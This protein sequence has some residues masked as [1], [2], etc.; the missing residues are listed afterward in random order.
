MIFLSTSSSRGNYPVANT[1][2]VSGKNKSLLSIFVAVC[3]F[4]ASTI[5]RSRFWKLQRFLLVETTRFTSRRRRRR[6]CD[7]KM[8]RGPS[9]STIYSLLSLRFTR[10]QS[11][12]LGVDP[13]SVR[14]LSSSAKSPGL[15]HIAI[16]IICVHFIM[17]SMKLGCSVC[18][19]RFIL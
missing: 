17:L 12:K 1:W 13:L 10:Q 9:T 6:N 15:Y 16:R 2:L 14:F 4:G 7:S 3:S 8:K 11:S 5:W 19:W 18:V